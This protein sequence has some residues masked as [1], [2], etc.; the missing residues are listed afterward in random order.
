VVG[1]LIVR[2]RRRSTRVFSNNDPNPSGPPMPHRREVTQLRWHME[3][4]LSG[5]LKAAILDYVWTLS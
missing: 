4:R 5:K 1:I 3:N 2:T